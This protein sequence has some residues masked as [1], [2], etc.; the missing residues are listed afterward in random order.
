MEMQQTIEKHWNGSADNYGNIIRR[1]LDSF[2]RKAWAKKL[3]K[4]LRINQTYLFWILV[5]DRDFFQLY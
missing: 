4:M 2:R 5:Q 3:Q 1:E